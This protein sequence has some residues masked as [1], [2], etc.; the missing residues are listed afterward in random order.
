[1]NTLQ[2]LSREKYSNVLVTLNPENPPAPALTQATYQ[3]RHPLYNAAMVAAQDRLDEIQGKDGIWFAGAWTGYGFHEDGCRSG[4]QVGI[5]LGGQLPWKPVDAK[6]MRGL[7]PVLGWK[8]FLVRM[9]VHA[10][11]MLIVLVG[12]VFGA[13]GEQSKKPA[14]TNGFANG[15]KEL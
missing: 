2:H 7:K 10:V 1:M 15:K 9:V 3:Y 14:L 5:K 11:Q 12:G 8:D 6:F 4:L 13:K